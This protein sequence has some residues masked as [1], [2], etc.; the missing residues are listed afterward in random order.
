MSKPQ[1]TS[2]Q[3]KA[4]D[5]QLTNPP[6]NILVSAAAG[7]GKTFV[8]IN[9]IVAKL[10]NE[11]VGEGTSLPSQ[12]INL[13]EMIIV[14]FTEAAASELKE[15]LD[16]ELNERLKQTD[17][18][19]KQ[20]L[21]KKQ[22]NYL[23]DAYI[24]TFHALYLRLLKE[25]KA[26]FKF[27]SPI[28]IINDIQ[29]M[30]LKQRCFK[31]LEQ[32]N[33]NKSDFLLL[34][35]QYDLPHYF[36]GLAELFNSTLN[37]CLAN[38]GIDQFIN[39]ETPLNISDIINYPNYGKNI[40]PALNNELYKAEIILLNIKALA[41]E[42]DAIVED[43]LNQLKQLKVDL[44]NVNSYA[45]LY[46]LMQNITKTTSIFGAINKKVYKD[47]AEEVELEYKQ[48]HK[49]LYNIIS[50]QIKE[51]I[52]AFNQEDYFKIIANN[53]D[54]IKSLLNYVKEY[55]YLIT[56]EKKR[57][58]LL[59]FDDL[60]LEMLDLLYKDN[61]YTDLALDMQQ[62]FKEIMIDEYQ[63]TSFNQD[64]IV[65]AISNTS[66]TFMVGD[67]KQ[68]IYK[69]R[70]ATPQ[71]FVDKKNEYQL[72][73]D[74]LLIELSHNFRSKKTVLDTT[75]FIF[76]NVF[77]QH[78]GQII[79]DEMQQ[80]NC[81]KMIGIFDKIFIEQPELTSD[82]RE[83]STDEMLTYLEDDTKFNDSTKQLIAEE[84]AQ[85]NGKP[86]KL[87]INKYDDNENYK[88]SDLYHK[89]SLA[90]VK[91]IQKL[92]ANNVD[93]KDITI[94]LRKRSNVEVLTKV[95]DEMNIPY[96]LHLK[97]GFFDSYP[98]KDLFN[99]LHALV[100]LS[101][102][103]Y[104]YASL[105]SYFFNLSSDDIYQLSLLDGPLI[106]KLEV[107]KHQEVYQII[108]QLLYLAKYSDPL[109]LINSI[110]TITPYLNLYTNNNNAEAYEE[111]MVHLNFLKQEIVNNLDYYTNLADFI[112]DL[113]EGI[114][115]KI[116]S[117]SPALLSSKSDVVNIMTI[118]RSKGLEFEYVF[119]IDESDLKSIN[120]D[121]IILY[122]NQ[123]NIKKYLD[124]NQEIDIDNPFNYLV[125]FAKQKEEREEIS[126]LFYVALTRAKE[127]LFIFRNISNEEYQN[128]VNA[129][130]LEHETPFSTNLLMNSKKMSDSLLYSVIYNANNHDIFSFN[131]PYLQVMPY[132]FEV[133]K[134]EKDKKVKDKSIKIKE[135]NIVKKEVFK[136]PARASMHEVNKLDFTKI[137]DFDTFKQGSATHKVLEL[138][139]FK[140]SN[141][142]EQ[143]NDLAH[144]F[145]L[146][147][148]NIAG[149]QAF[150]NDE[151]FQVIKDNTYY[152]EYSF[153]LE[154]GSIGIIDLF[155]ETDDSIYIIDYKSDHLSKEELKE[156]YSSQLEYYQKV[157]EQVS[158][159]KP[160]NLAIYSL[161]NKEFVKL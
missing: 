160:I 122:D 7:C 22:I 137:S 106:K 43:K 47:L 133:N 139:D 35:Q 4:I 14:T 32:A 49:K 33:L 151:M 19:D 158:S 80:L 34:K 93:Y 141:I 157:I 96:M 3:V 90:V 30:K 110:Y 103:S 71:I 129:L 79:Y 87:L 128:M 138:L 119:I 65:Q 44:T 134:V 36:G 2:A 60:E 131:K 108:K 62:Q 125:N 57:L 37:H 78:F 85:I 66:K 84:M 61:Q 69:F 83:K 41:P 101:D 46:E 114:K 64:K 76:K 26:E 74:H 111:L 161:H 67:V 102:E 82:I 63:D 92:K 126:R 17:N 150:I 56:S 143:L 127:Q 95:F 8:M 54:A 18:L 121:P 144:K 140:A 149:I 152:Q 77:S 123:L 91:E 86:T 42:F 6:R 89:T 1:F 40:I 5:E 73:N 112:T 20:E 105:H 13:N 88:V 146:N 45:E 15:K 159:S 98:I 11:S 53:N 68:S 118:H 81:G 31:Q 21:I 97:K 59:S 124:P 116:D 29:N 48:L 154:D 70:K 156:R 155:V 117:A 135:Y 12:P 120:K 9:R 27:D 50:K 24:S 55:Y 104:L 113:K 28:T 75:N 153:I 147:H 115:D 130:S 39:Q 132:D 16:K 148:D 38:G 52:F 94:L 51:K 25:N 99:L 142:H 145:K 72:D 109:T 100:D 10:L 107:S 136:K 58:G 23:S